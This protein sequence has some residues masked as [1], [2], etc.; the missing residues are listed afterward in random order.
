MIGLVRRPRVKEESG[1][2][3]RQGGRL[4]TL[5]ACVD[6]CTRV[7]VDNLWC[8]TIEVSLMTQSHEE[9]DEA[10]LAYI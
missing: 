10:T 1:G 9:N 2:A 7:S 8:M 3:G 5:A 6:Y 4:E